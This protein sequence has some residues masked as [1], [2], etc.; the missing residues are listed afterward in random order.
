[1]RKIARL[2][3]PLL[4]VPLFLGAP[5]RPAKAQADFDC[6]A[7]QTQMAMNVCAGEDYQAADEE[8]NAVWSDLRDA[9]R[10]SSTWQAILDAQRLWIPFRD[11]HCNA[12]AALYEGGSIQPLIRFSCLAHTTR[13]RTA[14]LRDLLM[15]P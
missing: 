15:Q 8:L 3:T 2:I 13:Q 7:P 11:A 9:R 12:E 6:K 1:M 5:T 4:L 10:D 14:Q